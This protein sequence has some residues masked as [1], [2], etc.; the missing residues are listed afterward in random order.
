MGCGC[1]KAKQQRFSLPQS[2]R[3]KSPAEIV[4]QS[5]PAIWLKIL[6]F[7]TIVELARVSSTCRFFR[8]FWN[9]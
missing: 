5:E 8:Y 4:L 6:D 3:N 1:G 2:K 7:L 9:F